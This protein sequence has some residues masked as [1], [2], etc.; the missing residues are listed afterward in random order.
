MTYENWLTNKQEKLFRCSGGE[1]KNR[2]CIPFINVFRSFSVIKLQWSY[3]KKMNDPTLFSPLQRILRVAKSFKLSLQLN[4]AKSFSFYFLD[5]FNANILFHDWSD[6]NCK[7]A[8][9]FLNKC[10]HRICCILIVFDPSHSW[11]NKC[12][13]ELHL[14]R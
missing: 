6:E 2:K 9:F 8:R 12:K 4:W 3:F 11:P 7:I 10:F 5:V 13:Y 14:A 1:T